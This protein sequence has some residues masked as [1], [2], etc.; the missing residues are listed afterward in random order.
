MIRD[1]FGTLVAI[2]WPDP[3]RAAKYD[4]NLLVNQDIFPVV[5]AYLADSP[6]PL[7]LMIKEKKAVLKG[8]TFLDNGVFFP[9]K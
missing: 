4:R 1:R 7:D 3:E 6:E 9:A 5:F 8:H 2:R